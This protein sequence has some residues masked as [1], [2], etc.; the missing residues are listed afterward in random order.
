MTTRRGLSTAGVLAIAFAGF[1]T[2]FDLYATQPLLPMFERLFHASEAHVGLTVSASMAAVALAAPFV[3]L[4]ADRASRKRVI[5]AS[6]V[7]LSLPTFFSAAAHGL[8][9]LIA[10]RFLA[11]LAVPGVYVLAI[12][13][14]TEEAGAGGAGSGMA[15]FVAGSALGGLTGRV[16]AGVVT[17][18]VGWRQAFVLLGAV[19][20]AGALVIERWLPPSRH[21]T[22]RRHDEGTRAGRRAAMRDPRL[23]A[24]YIIGF[25]LL[26]VLVA[27]FTYVTFYLSAAPF[28]LGTGALSGIFLVYLVGATIT[29]FAGRWIDRAGSR[30]VLLVS[31]GAGA[32]GMMLTMIPIL[33]AVVLGLAT[34]C[35]AAFVSQ[36][37]ATSYLRVA[38]PAPLRSLA[39]G[40]Y[41][42]LYYAGGGA[43]ALVPGLT[44]A[45]TGWRGC[46]ALVVVAQLAAALL[47]LGWWTAQ[48][49]AADVRLEPMG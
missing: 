44:W 17:A 28:L 34:V 20:L 6:V 4:L 37:C 12:A 9:E 45:R 31:L 40:L 3:G 13:Y 27:A 23:I 2:F 10:W 11:G 35:T 36:S 5:V 21:F 39:S 26:F 38:A 16:L 24:T 42:T 33:P 29:P 43:G 7:A 19:T 15:A 22:P 47:A 1:C 25:N 18:F 49:A 8:G 32:A 14:V 41:I 30:V 46:V 48:D